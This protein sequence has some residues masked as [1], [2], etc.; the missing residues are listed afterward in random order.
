MDKTLQK[1]LEAIKKQPKKRTRLDV[2][3]LC[4]S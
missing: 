3:I 2:Q 4:S 1:K